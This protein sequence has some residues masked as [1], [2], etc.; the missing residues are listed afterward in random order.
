AEDFSF[1]AQVAPGSF[2]RI[3]TNNPACDRTY[4]V[5]RADF[6]LDEDALPV[7][8]AALAAAALR[9]MQEKRSL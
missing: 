4:P 7:G 2:L 9:W 5:H 8:A 3:G 6:R 1:M